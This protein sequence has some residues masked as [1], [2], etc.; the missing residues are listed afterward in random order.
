MSGNS[1]VRMVL[2]LCRKRTGLRKMVGRRRWYRVLAVRPV[3][4][5]VWLSLL[6]LVQVRVRSSVHV[7]QTWVGGK[8]WG[9]LLSA[10]RRC[11]T[12]RGGETRADGIK[13]RLEWF[14]DFDV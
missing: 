8:R 11:G 5:R 12:S 4:V 1:L 14:L 7:L 3:I 13:G 10:V 2:R 6:G 9:M